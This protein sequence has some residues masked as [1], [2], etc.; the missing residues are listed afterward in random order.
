MQ[1][2][3]NAP[4]YKLSRV[5]G[6]KHNL[7]VLKITSGLTGESLTVQRLDDGKHCIDHPISGDD[8]REQVLRAYKEFEAETGRTHRIEEIQYLASDTPPIETY[9]LM[10]KEILR[11]VGASIA[12]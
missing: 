6:P 11:R 9:Y 7:L 4:F 12:D 5:T 3:D 1:F 8:V 10:T 2:I